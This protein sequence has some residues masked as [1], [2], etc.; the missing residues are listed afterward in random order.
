MS[1][2]VCIIS[3]NVNS[4]EQNEARPIKLRFVI[5]LENAMIREK[6]FRSTNKTFKLFA[7]INNF[8][9]V[10]DLRNECS[11]LFKKE[12]AKKLREK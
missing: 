8:R 5:N 12:D 1:L 9:E 3:Q 7:V 6:A 10:G 2:F 11:L 4:I